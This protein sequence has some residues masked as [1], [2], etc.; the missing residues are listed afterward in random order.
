MEV[1]RTKPPNASP[2]FE[3]I[4]QELREECA[5][6]AESAKRMIQAS[7]QLTKEAHQLIEQLH[8]NKRRAS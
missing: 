4:N 1:R 7:K 3:K 5:K 6:T 8:R 2:T